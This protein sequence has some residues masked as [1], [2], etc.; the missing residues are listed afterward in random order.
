[1]S[2]VLAF[3]Y[4][5]IY[6]SL[7][8]FSSALSRSTTLDQ[9]RQCLQ[10]QIKYLFDYQLV[11]F[12]FYQQGYYVT[13][14]L[15]PTGS[16]VV[17]GS[18]GLLWKHEQILSESHV[19]AI[20]DD[21]ALIADSLQPSQLRLPEKPTQIW[22]W[23]VAFSAD[24]GLIVSVF[25]GGDRQ[26]QPADV[27]ILR[28]AVENLYAKILSI[29]LIEELGSKQQELQLALS[30]LQEKNDVIAQLVATQEAVIQYRTQEL[31]HKNTR[32]LE[33]SRQHA[34]TIREPLSRIL[35]LAYLMETFSA[36]EIMEEMMPMLVVTSHDLDKALQQIISSI[37]ADLTTAG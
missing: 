24:S 2:T 7:S 12:S 14:S 16:N 23:H 32:L 18:A 5:L 33:V 1:M 35:S 29:K 27:P 8:R 4:R 37:D 6:E 19:P 20:L 21:A 10:G 11:R 31:E 34:H 28:I 26:F 13:F 22:G 3:K 30:N 9:V 17:C 15:V 36:E 25:S